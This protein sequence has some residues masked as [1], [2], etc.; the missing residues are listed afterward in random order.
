MT[1]FTTPEAFMQRFIEEVS[2]H[3]ARFKAG[4]TITFASGT[5]VAFA[6][7]VTRPVVDIDGDTTLTLAQSG[8]L[9]LFTVADADVTLPAITADD[10]GVY[11]D[12]GTKISA[13]DQ[14][15]I[16]QSGDLLEGGL[17][18]ID[19]DDSSATSA[20][21]F[22]DASDDLLITMNGTTTGGEDTGSKLRVTADEE[23]H[24]YVE[25]LLVGSGAIVTPFA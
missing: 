23:G 14:G 16:A 10:A 15:I 1:E 2:S 21:F 20:T 8:S 25:G 3:E 7:A 19:N 11:F 5:T 24:W 9:C 12:F 4:T 17:A 6:G 18:I 13:T 22:P